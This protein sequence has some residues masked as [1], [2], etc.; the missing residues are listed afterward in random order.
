MRSRWLCAAAIVALVIGFAPARAADEV[1]APSGSGAV[2]TPDDFK[3]FAP[4]T[5]LDMLNQAPG[6]V[7]REESEAR[8]LG[9][10][11]GNVLLNGK[12]ASAKSDDVLAQLSRIPAKNVVRIEI[13][14]GATLDVPGLY[15][16]VANVVTK[17]GALSGQYSWRA[18]TRVHNT[19]RSLSRFTS[20]VSGQKGPVEFTLS[21][22][23]RASHGGADG[24]TTIYNAD[25]SVREERRDRLTNEF[26]QPRGAVTLAITGPKGVVF[27]IHGNYRKFWFDFDELGFRSG[28]GLPDRLRRD[29]ERENGFDYESGA[30][31][32]FALGPGRLKL[33]G[34][35]SGGKDRPETYILTDFPGGALRQADFFAQSSRTGEGIGRFEYRW[36]SLGSDFQISG[37]AALNSLDTTSRLASLDDNGLLTD[38]PL[39]GGTARVAEKRY[40]TIATWGRPLGVTVSVQV[41][42]GVERSTL[43]QV[44]GGGVERTFLRPKGTA[45][46]TWKASDKTTV[47]LRLARRV[48]QLDFL[49]F[50][51]R[52]D[53]SDD[54]QNAG[55]VDL[56]PQQSWELE[57]EA[58]RNFGKLG[59]TSLR[60]YAQRITDIV[61]IVPIGAD[62][63]SIGNLD[64]AKVY[65]LESRSTLTLDP[66]GWKGVKI[67]LTAQFENSSVRDPLTGALRPISNNLIRLIDLS[68]RY[69]VPHTHW[70]M[71]GGLFNEKDA[72]AF[73]LTEIGRQHEGPV[74]GSVFVEYKDF[75]GL[76][77]NAQARDLANA[78]SRFDRI[79]YVDRR[80]GPI[81]FIEDRNRRIGP[82][83]SFT[84]SGKF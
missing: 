31:A 22:E 70:A 5:A 63:E 15:G 17:A 78:R 7:I 28:P 44:G 18:E 54:R 75:K 61:D 76:T 33:L 40:E 3:Q 62:G 35:K 79:A 43:A 24:P 25:G 82:I 69:D 68:A 58:S 13:V 71:G 81:D 84:I 8:G 37:E 42:A 27:N 57:G 72:P 50:L 66:I 51:A 12:R 23:N 74:F 11:S 10:A 9:E 29:L 59:S 67:D 48:G 34:L 19:K 64:G 52:V 49:D 38:I 83:F 56:R 47:T 60:L 1:K 21:L 80:D 26:D 4:R 46:A 30:D 41:A 53:L 32:E 6:F 36:K 77:L 65:G 20:S 73:R 39:P 45:T 2:Y 14:D 55:N 16:Q